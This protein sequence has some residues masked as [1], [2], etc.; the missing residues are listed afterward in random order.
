MAAIGQQSVTSNGSRARAALPDT[1]EYV[2]FV[3]V[4]SIV[5]ALPKLT[6]QVSQVALPILSVIPNLRDLATE[7]VEQTLNPGGSLGGVW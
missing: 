2:W 3:E 4:M 5:S 1:S 7:F 6:R